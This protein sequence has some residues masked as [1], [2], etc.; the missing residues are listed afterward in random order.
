MS[1]GKETLHP[2]AGRS[3]YRVQILSHLNLKRI[4][5][6]EMRSALPDDFLSSRPVCLS[7]SLL[8]QFRDPDRLIDMLTSQES[9][10]KPKSK[11]KSDKTRPHPRLMTNRDL[12]KHA[13][14]TSALCLDERFASTW[15][16]KEVGMFVL[17]DPSLTLLYICIKFSARHSLMQRTAWFS[18]P[19]RS[20]Q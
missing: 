9:E 6:S 20:S 16:L 19:D 12:D 15:N 4:L 8:K 3:R 18:S 7:G 1:V 11:S 14:W 2:G 5:I 17:Y 10:S 13:P